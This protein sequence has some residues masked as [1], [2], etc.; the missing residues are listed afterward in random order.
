MGQHTPDQDPHLLPL[1]MVQVS[2]QIV[3]FDRSSL[4]QENRIPVETE[5]LPVT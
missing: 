3:H 4:Q 1:S 2:F 5:W